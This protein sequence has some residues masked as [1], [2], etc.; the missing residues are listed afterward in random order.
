M[1]YGGKTLKFGEAF[2]E[3]FIQFYA[4]QWEFL[5]GRGNIGL[6]SEIN[7]FDTDDNGS[8][9]DEINNSKDKGSDKSE[10][11]GKEKK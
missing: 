10:K 9:K 6:L 7:A 11:G 8:S 3:Y 1:K 5:G 2:G 4:K